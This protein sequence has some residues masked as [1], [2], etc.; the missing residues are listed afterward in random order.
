MEKPLLQLAQKRVQSLEG[1]P[2]AG[3]GF[4]VANGKIEGDNSVRLL[5]IAGDNYVIPAEHSE[6]FSIVDLLGGEPVPDAAYKQPIDVLELST[7]SLRNT[8]VLPS[9]YVHSAGAIPLLGTVSLTK[10]TVF[11]RFIG[12]STDPRL[13]GSTLV[14]DTYMTT[15]SD[16]HYANTGFAAVGRYALP[17]PVPASHVFEYELPTNTQLVVGTV[18]PNFGQAGGG[19]E[20]KTLRPVSVVASKYVPRDDF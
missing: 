19:V 12:S 5:I 7:A 17:I 9:G 1:L 6:F 3:M 2:E 14:K 20:V 15:A 13:S 4:Y 16:Q 11:Y 8:T 10:N 18:L